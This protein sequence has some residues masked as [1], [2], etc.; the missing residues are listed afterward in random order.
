V[1]ETM[2]TQEEAGTIRLKDFVRVVGEE[3]VDE[4]R[5]LASRLQGKSVTHINSTAYGGGVAEI[6]YGM[7]P[8]MRDCGF[9]VD[10]QVIK[11]SYEFFNVT[12]KIHNALQGLNVDLTDEERKIYI[13]YNRTNSELRQIDSDFVVVHDNQPAP[14]IE[15]FP[16]R[17]GKW[18][19]RCHVDLSTPNIVVW[20]FLEQFISHYNAAIF[21]SEKYVIPSLRVPKTAIIPPS[22]NPLSDKNREIPEDLVAELL[23]KFSVATDKP[24]IA[25]VGRFDRW[26]DTLGAIDV[27]RLVKKEIPQVQLCLIASMANDDPEGWLYFEKAARHAGDDGDIHMLTDLIGVKDLEVNAF[28]RSSNVVL[29]MSTREGF[30]L[31]VSEA[32]WKGVPVVGRNV[33]G[34]PLQIVDGENGYLVGSIQEA[35]DKTVHLLKNVDEAKKMGK[36]GR[37]RV[38]R[39]FLVTQHLKNYF[40][41]FSDL[42]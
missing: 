33:G 19:W 8:L 2:M 11:G 34:I 13:E 16:T 12:K 9:D 25:Q 5:A 32:M 10:W 1:Q 7:V 29:Q 35:A 41:L 26:K 22:I 40:R 4:I 31:T 3:E 17:H 14:L 36:A 27:Y 28:Q 6:L 24:I 38:L 42:S 30:G 18:I 23:E 37:E 20:N 21:S 39:N 15:F